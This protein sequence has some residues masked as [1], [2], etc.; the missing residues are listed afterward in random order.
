MG[1]GSWP[2]E[3][4]GFKHPLIDPH[5]DLSKG[6]RF[7]QDLARCILGCQFRRAH[8]WLLNANGRVTPQQAALM[9]GVPIVCG[10][11]EK[12]S[13]FAADDK[14]LDKAGLHPQLALIVC[15]QFNA[16]PFSKVGR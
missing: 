7:S 2:W 11:V 9:L 3:R 12:L 15:R 8:R 13:R 1:D 5:T 4:E 14:A 16:H 6:I 10:L